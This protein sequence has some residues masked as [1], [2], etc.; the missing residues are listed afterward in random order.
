MVGCV[1]EFDVVGRL[2]GSLC[3]AIINAITKDLIK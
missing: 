1:E 3:I 2:L